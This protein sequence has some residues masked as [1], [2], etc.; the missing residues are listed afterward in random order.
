LI[1]PLGLS[2]RDQTDLVAFLKSLTDQE[3]VTDPRFRNP[4]P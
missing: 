1:R 2:E 3:F 4:W